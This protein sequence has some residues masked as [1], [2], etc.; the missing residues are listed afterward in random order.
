MRKLILPLV[1]ASNVIL[2]ASEPV[3]IKGMV[4]RPDLFP[5]AIYIENNRGDRCT[6]TVIGRRALLTAAHCIEDSRVIKPVDATIHPFVAS[7]D[8]HPL[9][10]GDDFDIAICYSENPFDDIEPASLSATGPF[11][12]EMITLS[13]YGCTSSDRTGGN[14]GL[15]RYGFSRVDVTVG[16]LNS[17]HTSDDSTI[18]SGDS[19]GA[20]YKFDP[21]FSESMHY[22]LGVNARSN[23]INRSIFQAV[24]TPLVQNFLKGWSKRMHTSICGLN[25]NCEAPF[26]PG[27]PRPSKITKLER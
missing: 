13:G 25:R 14:D 6:G 17:F 1:L 12:G 23:F 16:L 27:T 26:R 22:V 8:I 24:F 4:A 20:S 18:C 11:M 19:G 2:N 3:I 7:C 21:N 10:E 5:E 15:F 9:Y